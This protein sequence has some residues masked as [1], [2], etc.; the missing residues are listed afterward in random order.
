MQ[1]SRSRRAIGL[2]A[3]VVAALAFVIHLTAVMGAPAA[4][5]G[6]V[7]IIYALGIASWAILLR[8]ANLPVR[9]G[10]ARDPMSLIRPLPTWAT[11]LVAA[12]FFYAI[13]NFLLFFQATGGGTVERDANGQAVLSDHGRVI[14]TLDEN[15]VRAVEVWQVRAFSGL[16]L[17]FLVL[18]GLYF[19]FASRDDAERD[20]RSAPHA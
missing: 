18:P 11:L 5:M 19:L 9:H 20:R 12:V 4:G 8:H 3:L 6:A 13:L 16:I 1:T 7:F 2:A 15:G 17:P 14:R 10:W